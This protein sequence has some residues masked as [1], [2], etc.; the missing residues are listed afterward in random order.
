MPIEEALQDCKRLSRN[1]RG[2]GLDR[3]S[4]ARFTFFSASASCKQIARGLRVRSGSTSSWH[5]PF[6]EKSLF[7]NLGRFRERLA[8]LLWVVLS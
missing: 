7:R 4:Q 8:T 2:D 6:N 1:L 5:T 3:G